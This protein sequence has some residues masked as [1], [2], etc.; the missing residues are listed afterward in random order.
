MT[1]AVIN[2]VGRCITIC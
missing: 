1:S 2:I